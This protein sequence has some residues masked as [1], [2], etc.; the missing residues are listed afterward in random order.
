MRLALRIVNEWLLRAHSTQLLLLLRTPTLSCHF[1]I[2]LS[3]SVFYIPHFTSLHRKSLRD[4]YWCIWFIFYWHIKRKKFFSASRS[5]RFRRS[6]L[7]DYI[8]MLL[9]F[10]PRDWL[11]ITIKLMLHS[12]ERCDLDPYFLIFSSKII[13]LGLFRNLCPRQQQSRCLT[14]MSGY[15]TDVSLEITHFPKS[16]AP[17]VQRLLHIVVTFICVLHSGHDST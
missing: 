4:K 14:F 10:L 2:D 6:L 5:Y 7:C 11:I 8:L 16:E 13:M 3:M 17:L 12:R 9:H 15:I 1:T